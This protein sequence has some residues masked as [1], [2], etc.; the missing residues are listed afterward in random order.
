[1][2]MIGPAPRLNGRK[3]VNGHRIQQILAA[4]CEG[5]TDPAA[6]ELEVH[7]NKE[8]EPQAEGAQVHAKPRWKQIKGY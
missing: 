8:P 1:M 6:E 3:E 2:G 5:V 4:E 7:S